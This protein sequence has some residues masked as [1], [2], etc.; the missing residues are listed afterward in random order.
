MKLCFKS[1]FVLILSALLILNGCSSIKNADKPTIQYW[2][3]YD[4]LLDYAA[5]TDQECNLDIISYNGMNRTG[6]TWQQM[7][8]GD[9]PDIF[10]CG[11]N[12]D[13][14]LASERL[15][16]L[17]SY[18]FTGEF[19]TSIMDKQSKNGGIYLLPVDYC[20]YGIYY[21]KTLMEE[22]GWEVP[23]NFNELKTL[24]EKIKEAGYIP[25][26]IGTNLL[27]NTFSICF[28]LAKTDWLSTPKGQKWEQDFL[29]GKASAKDQW[30]GTMDLVQDYIDIGMFT[31]D[32]EDRENYE[33]IDDY[34][35]GRKA[36]FFSCA[37]PARSTKLC[38]G[39]ELGLMPYI[40][41]DGSK[42][43]YMYSTSSYIG[44]NKSLGEKG[45]EKKLEEALKFME[46]L[47]SKKGQDILIGKDD[48]AHM[49]IRNVKLSEDS[50]LY[51]AQKA[52]WEGRA[53]PMTY[54]GWDH[55]LAE[56]GLKF[57]EWIRP[58]MDGSRETIMEKMDELIQKS[59]S[60]DNEL[61]LAQAE[62]DFTLKETAELIGKAYGSNTDADAVMLAYSTQ[63]ADEYDFQG[64]ISGKLYKG[65][66][67]RNVA[68]T[69]LHRK[70]G[71]YSLMTMSGKEAKEIQKA[72]FQP[73]HGWP[74]C[75]YVLVTPE[76]KP[77]EDDKTYKILFTEDGYDTDLE[78]KFKT[79]KVNIN[80]YNVW[81]DYLMQEKT[82][83]PDKNIWK[84]K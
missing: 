63:V 13:P 54:V 25:G 56:I 79:E 57:K 77:L 33:M 62:K 46:L 20:I 55:I 69:I 7:K 72:G 4:D 6:Y 47:Y 36:V 30:D 18:N 10:I 65:P 75:P 5:K 59:L 8:A 38:N 2:Y 44:L 78:K 3:G 28:N 45:N 27:G 1:F 39:D 14:E 50:I 61:I 17:S 11:Q 70:D 83:A 22:N 41:R 12:L 32:P 82:V 76:N 42:N 80:L 31:A 60:E 68:T 19:S 35:G 29:V 58:D 53:F 16:D 73:E 15:L 48:P 66:I 37:Q 84:A 23:T 64:G 43:V 9:I 34:L 67:D 40:S 51:D 49:T 21:N 81:A 71:Q 26:M 52:M 74:N 24:C